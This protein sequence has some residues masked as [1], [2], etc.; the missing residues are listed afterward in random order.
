MDQAAAI[1][2]AP[3]ARSSEASFVATPLQA[4]PSPAPIIVN[5]AAGLRTR[6]TA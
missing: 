4:K 6:L 1:N 3:R 5:E 2:S